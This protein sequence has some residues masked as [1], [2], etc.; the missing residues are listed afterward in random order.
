MTGRAGTD[1]EARHWSTLRKL[2][3]IETM[4]LMEIR[5][6][7]GAL[8]ISAALINAATAATFYRSQTF[9]DPTIT[10]G[11]LFG[12]SV[13]ISGNNLLIGDRLDN[14]NGRI[15]GQAHLFS[16]YL[17]P[18]PP[19]PPWE[20]PPGVPLPASLPLFGTG[21]ALLGTIGWRRKRKTVS[22]A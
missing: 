11:D 3:R 4:T 13:A 20:P 17:P 9:D 21:L 7:A 6:L 2:Q 8:V 10:G 15:V 1:H 12:Y 22:T 5:I 16:T 18:A 19:V 14:T